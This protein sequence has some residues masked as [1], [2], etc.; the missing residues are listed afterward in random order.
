[1][2]YNLFGNSEISLI[3][4]SEM[5]LSDALLVWVDANAKQLENFIL[6]S[7][8]CHGIFR[9]VSFDALMFTLRTIRLF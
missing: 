2:L 4:Y 3:V 9:Q 7:K 8:D 6:T 1:M 5:H